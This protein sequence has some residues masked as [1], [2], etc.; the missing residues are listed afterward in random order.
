[1]GPNVPVTSRE[2]ACIAVHERAMLQHV[3][4][5][6]RISKGAKG[7]WTYLSY[8]KEEKLPPLPL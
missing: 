5:H 6:R 4:V 1:M 7:G 3:V 8:S 2:H